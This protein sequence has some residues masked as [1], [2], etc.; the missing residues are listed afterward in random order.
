MNVKKAENYLSG[1]NVKKKKLTIIY[2]KYRKNVENYLFF[3][4]LAT[5]AVETEQLKDQTRK[6]RQRDL[7]YFVSWSDITVIPIFI[8]D[9]NK[10]FE[11]SNHF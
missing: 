1:I 8:G 5:V 11:Q 10:M 9:D 3:V 7:G 6:R 4:L 2:P